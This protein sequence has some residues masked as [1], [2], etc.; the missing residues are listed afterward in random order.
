M[1]FA[2]QIR[3]LLCP[4]LATLQAPTTV[5]VSIPPSAFSCTKV[6]HLGRL[7]SP[8]V[9]ASAWHLE[10]LLKEQ[11]ST[12]QAFTIDPA[13]SLH[14]S[15]DFSFLIIFLSLHTPPP[16]AVFESPPFTLILPA[17]KVSHLG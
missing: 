2:L 15:C 13:R 8:M 14:L 17:T 5:S 11:L 9:I 3:F 12:L 1:K 7:P 4:Q 6:S 10:F 16:P